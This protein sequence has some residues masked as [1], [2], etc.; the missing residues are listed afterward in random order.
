MKFFISLS[1]LG[2]E[3]TLYVCDGRTMEFFEHNPSEPWKAVSFDSLDSANDFISRHYPDSKI[4][5]MVYSK[6]D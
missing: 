2:S 3:K 4:P 1:C 5:V 6:E